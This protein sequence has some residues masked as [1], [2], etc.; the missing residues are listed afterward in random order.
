MNENSIPIH[1]RAPV[2]GD[3]VGNSWYAFRRSRITTM[4]DLIFQFREFRTLGN[5]LA[6]D[7]ATAFRKLARAPGIVGK[8]YLKH[9]LLTRHRVAT[10]RGQTNPVDIRTLLPARRHI[11]FPGNMPSCAGFIGPDRRFPRKICSK[12]CSILWPS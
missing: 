9:D 6:N 7:L 4:R 11:F 3:D 10:R 5:V 12:E 2:H 1:H 8:S